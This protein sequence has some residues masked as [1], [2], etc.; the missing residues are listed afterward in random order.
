MY[1]RGFGR[2]TGLGLGGAAVLRAPVSFVPAPP[3]RFDVVVDLAQDVG[4]PRWWR[5]LFTCLALC[6][7]ALAGA[8]RFGPLDGGGPRGWGEEARR[9]VAGLAIAPGRDGGRTGRRMAATAAVED[10]P[11]APERAR[12]EL[13]AALVPGAGFAA[14]LTRAGVGADEAARAAAL[15]AE[16]VRL[17]ALA[18]GTPM[19]VVL[20]RRAGRGVA[21]PLL[22]L[23]FRAGLDLKLGVE[24]AEG[25]LVLRRTPVAVDRRPARIGGAVGEGFFLS[26]GAAG[27]GGRAVQD[28]LRAL[29]SYLD[30][31]EL[32][33]GDRFDMIVEQARA[34][35]GEA[36]QGAL[37][38]AGLQREGERSLRLVRWRGGW[39]D[40]DGKPPAVAEGAAASASFGGSIRPVP[41]RV[42]SRFGPRRH[43]ILGFVRM[44]KGMDF[45]AGW[46]TPIR[47][48]AAG[49]A[50]R[51]GWSGGYG[52]QVRLAHGG[53]LGTSY[54]HLSSY[55]VDEGIAVAAG[56]VIGFVG[57]SGLSTGPHLHYE[58]YL[59]GRAVD[60]AGVQFGAMAP[61]AA[62]A[63]SSDLPQVKARL[64][65]LLAAV[66]KP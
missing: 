19:R 62:A 12:V 32:R 30:V 44:H 53:G 50:V 26:A 35:T 13:I 55:A 22:S 42:T 49:V 23:E 45:G 5:G 38:Y 61:P 28:W 6:G 57:S 37:L 33:P 60:P 29:G 41:G 58:A 56:Q 65:A 27:A 36:R 3:P 51:V 66:T 8:P 14:G 11:T 18:A 64:A 21:R 2:G 16:A 24:R 10:L 48:P 47:A 25:A 46:G 43:P 4:S 1:A 39:A 40:A 17:D 7:T 59:G 52:R 31:G 20:G 63:P 54:S 34:E 15:V 9:E